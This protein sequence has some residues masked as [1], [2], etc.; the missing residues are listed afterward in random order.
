MSD[1]LKIVRAVDGDDW[2]CRR[3]QVACELAGV[4]YERTVLLRVTQAVTDGIVLSGED[5][6]TVD[7]SGVTDEAIIAAV[8]AESTSKSEGGA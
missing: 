7:T 2:F 4:T 3:V 6:L 5:G 8:A 1:L